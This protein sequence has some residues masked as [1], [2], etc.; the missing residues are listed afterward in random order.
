MR[1][2]HCQCPIASPYVTEYGTFCE[3]LCAVLEEEEQ[4]PAPPVRT[5]LTNA[6]INELMDS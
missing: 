1:C 5:K 3:N 4:N 6:E 2:T